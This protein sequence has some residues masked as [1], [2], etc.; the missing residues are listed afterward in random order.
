M[1]WKLKPISPHAVESALEKAR[2]YRLLN[3][4]TQAESICLDVLSAEEGNQ[5]ALITL[6]LAMT[7][8]FGQG[9]DSRAAGAYAK[10][11]SGE[12]EREYYSG[13]I[14][15][16]GAWSLLR[17]ETPG[18]R[19]DAYDLLRSAMERYE[20]AEKLRPA[21][22]DDALLRWN[23]CA[24]YLDR[25]PEVGPRPAEAFEPILSE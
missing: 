20:R 23:T 15:E 1:T 17:Q 2:L 12:Y 6:I 7:D 14:A 18:A 16:R 21:G 24:R 3:E 8:Q 5:P 9:T 25:H 19:F 22:N 10:K 4:P 13:I 11:L